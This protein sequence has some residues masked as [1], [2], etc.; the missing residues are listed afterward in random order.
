MSHILPLD[1]TY[2]LVLLSQFS[3]RKLVKLSI[4]KPF[5]T[6]FYVNRYNLDQTE[7]RVPVYKS[8]VFANV[9]K[10]QDDSNF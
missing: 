7:T 6:V 4:A 8:T 2:V 9:L 1:L 10:A 5:R 3:L